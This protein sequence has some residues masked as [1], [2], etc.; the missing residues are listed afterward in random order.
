MFYTKIDLE[1][2]INPDRCS[3]CEASEQFEIW[4]S[5]NAEL[6]TRCLFSGRKR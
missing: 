2:I 3:D 5:E 1:N 6:Q 4:C